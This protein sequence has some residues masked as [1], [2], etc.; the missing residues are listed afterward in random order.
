MLRSIGIVSLIAC[1]ALAACAKS[2]EKNC[3]P[4]A[5]VACACPDGRS[6][7]QQCASD[8]SKLSVCTC[9][10]APAS[11]PAAAPVAQ[12]AP[13]RVVYTTT[14][15]PLDHVNTKG[16]FLDDAA[17]ILRQDRA[18]VHAGITDPGDEVDALYA[19]DAERAKLETIGKASNLSTEVRQ[20]ILLLNPKVRVEVFEDRVA[21]TLLDSGTNEVPCLVSDGRIGGVLWNPEERAE[22]SQKLEMRGWKVRRT[23]SETMLFHPDGSI[24][25]MNGDWGFAA[26]TPACTT[27]GGTRLG[28]TL[29]AVRKD[30]GFRQAA[31]VCTKMSATQNESTEVMLTTGGGAWMQY[32]HATCDRPM[33]CEG[34]DPLYC[35]GN[36][37]RK[38]CRVTLLAMGMPSG[39]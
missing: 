38:D 13:P 17:G 20:A 1:A 37:G 29:D 5:T 15:G 12:V 16:V 24:A 23:P 25:A 27:P 22:V 33:K 11:A 28:S 26:T 8:G 30:P 21:V 18:R 10:A 7:A 31:C 9:A 32:V 35:A 39:G 3:T 34:E 19:D 14:L 4:G 2:P 6:G 36:W